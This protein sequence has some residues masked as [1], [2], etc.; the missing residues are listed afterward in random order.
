STPS[1]N[2]GIGVHTVPTPHCDDVSEASGRPPN[3]VRNGPLQSRVPLVLGQR[4]RST[5]T[6]VV[7]PFPR[8]AYNASRLGAR[9]PVPADARKSSVRSGCQRSETLGLVVA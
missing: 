4:A 8:G 5:T 2:E 1:D 9:P 6:P 3:W 7:V